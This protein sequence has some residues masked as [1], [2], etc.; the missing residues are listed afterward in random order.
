VLLDNQP[1]LASQGGPTRCWCRYR[2][3][4]VTVRYEP[5]AFAGLNGWADDDHLAAFQAFRE[6]AHAIVT[7]R[8]ANTALIAACR[9]GLGE[10]VVTAAEAQAFFERT[11]QPHRVVHDGPAGLLTGYY[12]PVIAGSLVLDPPFTVPIYRRP[13]DLENMVAE[14]ER[15]SRPDGFSHM[16]LTAGGLVPYATR[17]EIEEGALAGLGLEVVY[18]AD[19]VEA[20]FLHV[21]GSGAIRLGDG[22][23]LRITYDGKNGYPYTSVGRTMIE[24]GLF[25]AAELTLQVMATWLRAHPG[26]ARQI[27]WRNKSFVF[28]RPL[29]GDHPVGVLGTPLHDGR[30]LAVDTAFHALGLPVYV[31]APAMM[32]VAP[33]GFHRLM[34]AHDVGSAIKGPERGDI[35]FGTGEPA[36]ALAGITKHA[37]TFHVLLPKG[38][39][40]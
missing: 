30:S 29:D 5:L 17:Q 9:A 28:F 14:S 1:K 26:Q 12:E 39:T 27:L 31:S 24:D 11:F 34:I 8:P 22:Q 13:A 25:T 18:L 3:M 4:T 32:H 20:F 37:G 19:P 36:L 16:R 40:P 15:A 6:S 21:Q 7:A 23:L 10:G 33:G 35:Y 2:H 38:A